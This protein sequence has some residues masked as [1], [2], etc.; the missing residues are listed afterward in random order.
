MHC[1]RAMSNMHDLTFIL[2]ISFSSHFSD[3]LIRLWR[4]SWRLWLSTSDLMTFQIFTSSANIL[5]LFLIHSGKSFT[6][7]K[8][9]APLTLRG[10]SGRCRNIKGEP[11]I[12]GS[13]PNSRPRP[14]VLWMWFYGGPG[15]TPELT[16]EIN[17]AY[18][19]RISSIL[20]MFS[21]VEGEPQLCLPQYAVQLCKKKTREP[22]NC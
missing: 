8:Q 2:A 5:M 16:T 15:N 19:Q 3:H 11:Q 6:S 10:Q 12:Y 7:I 13:F 14:L 1:T 9:V 18:V 21:S 20:V 4:F 17:I 22:D